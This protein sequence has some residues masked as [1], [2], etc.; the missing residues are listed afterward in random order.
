MPLSPFPRIFRVLAQ[1][2]KLLAR[3]QTNEMLNKIIKTAMRQLTAL[4]VMK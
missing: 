4:Q 1:K 2:V 3:G